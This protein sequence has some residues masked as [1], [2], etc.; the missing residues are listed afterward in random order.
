VGLP[1]CTLSLY[2]RTERNRDH[3]RCCIWGRKGWWA[4]ALRIRT[5]LVYRNQ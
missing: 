4:S 1:Y 5:Y 3:K 2:Y